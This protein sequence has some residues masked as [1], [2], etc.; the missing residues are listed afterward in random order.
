MSTDHLSFIV[1][2]ADANIILNALGHMPFKE[3]AP[4]IQ[5]LHQQANEQLNPQ[6]Q[7]MPL[8]DP[9]VAP[10]HPLDIPNKPKVPTL[11]EARDAREGVG[12]EA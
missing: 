1:P 5:N 3:V 11:K 2:I 6:P 8:V 9:E 10:E 4:L 7:E 12:K